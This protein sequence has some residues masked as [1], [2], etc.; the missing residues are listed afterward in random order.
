MHGRPH[1]DS[2]QSANGSKI[3]VSNHREPDNLNQ[4]RYIG[5]AAPGPAKLGQLDRRISPLNPLKGTSPLPSPRGGGGRA[6]NKNDER[7]V[8]L[9]SSFESTKAHD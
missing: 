4:N 9:S 6:A 5:A 1:E 7:A 8:D 3:S 2:A